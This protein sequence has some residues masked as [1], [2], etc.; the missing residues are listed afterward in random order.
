MRVFQ[1]SS[2]SMR[3]FAS[4]LCSLFFIP[5]ALSAQVGSASSNSQ[6]GTITGRVTGSD[7]G[8]SLIG[9]TVVLE[10][11]KKGSTTD[12][13]GRYSIKNIKPGT[14]TLRVSYISY[15]TKQLKDIEVKAGQTLTQNFVLSLDTKNRTK[16]V[17]VVAKAIKETQAAAVAERKNS[18]QVSEVISQEEIKKAPD[19]D[20]GQALKRVSGVTLVGDK[21]V[22]V[23][24]ISDRYNGT[25][26]NGVAVTST[27]PDKKAFAFD[28]FPTE[29]LQSASVTKSFTPDLPGNFAGGLVQLNTVDF[30]QGY[31]LKVNT[32]LS[33]NDNVTGKANQFQTYTGGST[34]WLG[35]DNGARQMPSL[36]PGSRNEMDQVL[37]DIR[38]YYRG[39]TEPQFEQAANRWESMAKN[40]NPGLWNRQGITAGPNGGFG[41]SFSNLYSPFDNDLGVIASVN[42]SNGVSIAN[43]ER[44]G[45][46]SSQEELFYTNGTISNRSVNLGAMLN[47][48]TKLGDGNTLSLRNLYNNSS[49][50]EVVALGGYNVA[51]TRDLRLLSMDFTQK[52]LLSSQLI[53]E[54][55]LDFLGNTSVDWRVGYSVSER[56]QP[57]FRRLRYSRNRGVEEELFIADIQA[58]P[59]GDGTLAG[60]FK[61]YLKDDALNGSV[62]ITI[63]Y[64][65]A[66]IKFGGLAEDRNRVFNTRSFTYVQSKIFSGGEPLSDTTLSQSPDLIFNPANFG[67]DGLGISEDSKPTDSYTANE[68]LYAGYAMVDFPFTIADQEFRIITGARIEDNT[69]RLETPASINPVTNVP[70]SLIKTDLHTFDVLPSLNIIYKYDDKTNFRA[71][72]T[73]TLARPSL[74]EFAPFAFF[75][76]QD[77]AVVRGNKDLTRA[78]IQNYDLRWEYFPGFAQV[79]SAGVFYKSFK[80]AIE[81]TIVP[82]ASEIERSFQNASGMANNYGFE[83]EARKNFDF[84][85]DYF[86]NLLFSV[87]YSWIRSEV[88]VQQG[89][90]TDRRALWGQS[91]YSLNLGLF[92]AEPEWKTQFNMS[93]N[94]SGKRII[95]VGQLGRY[96]F[97]DPHVYELPRDVVDISISQPI[98]D[99]WN[100]RF[101]ARDLLNQPLKWQQGNSIVMSQV[102]GRTFGL[103]VSYTFR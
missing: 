17:V 69:T 12:T 21:F 78:L 101:T 60:R 6:F 74:R 18:S 98:A 34:D 5:F 92:F 7:N 49:D 65:G 77:L 53:G 59:Q 57:D 68:R 44:R 64:E 81:E 71:S 3:L 45:I 80:N 47:I 23:R 2:K 1:F 50:D 10:G 28:M 35:F 54:H 20:A 97:A 56:D 51:Q 29:F 40:Y 9:A 31:S 37:R 46:S 61:S 19:S 86:Q 36:L 89:L 66:K 39:N 30:P 43:R 83:L 38:Q 8:E 16:E 63:P 72:A 90:V 22:Y 82:T 88:E 62:N 85:S 32:S 76:F 91:P 27:E 25:T 67:R 14:Y 55:V 84:V 13:K 93:Y 99:A 94:I 100:I 96:E 48:S 41:V 11:S 4:I 70:D 95:Q 87:N 33:A 15:Q 75:D 102:R 103:S 42:Y 52:S 26:L 58:L 24:G 79:F 73:Q